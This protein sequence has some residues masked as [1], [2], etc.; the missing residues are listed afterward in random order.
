MVVI[1]Q[2]INNTSGTVHYRNTVSNV[3]VDV[4]PQTVDWQSD[5]QIPSS[6]CIID[7]VPSYDPTAAYQTNYIQISINDGPTAQISDDSNQLSVTGY[8][9]FSNDPVKKN[10]GLFSSGFQINLRIDQGSG[11]N[12]IL[13]FLNP[14]GPCQVSN[15]PDGAYVAYSVIYHGSD[16]AGKAVLALVPVWGG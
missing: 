12:A 1:A 8:Y 2:V 15:G 4:P 14:Q 7:T 11:G 13:S 6:G 16:T 10:Y 9:P 3:S 5:N